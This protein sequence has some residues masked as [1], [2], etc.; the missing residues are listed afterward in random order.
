MVRLSRRKTEMVD[1]FEVAGTTGHVI[2][3]ASIADGKVRRVY[4][5]LLRQRGATLGGVYFYKNMGATLGPTI[6]AFEF[7]TQDQIID[8]P[9][10][11]LQENAIPIWRDIDEATY[12]SIF[13]SVEVASVDVFLKYADEPKYEYMD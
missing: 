7:D 5:V 10:G 9:G 8:L 6:Q 13:V 4:Q 2:Q 12:D 3:G 11:P 1:I